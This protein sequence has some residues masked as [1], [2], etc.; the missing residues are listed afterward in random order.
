MGRLVLIGASAILAGHGLI[1]LI[2]AAVYLRLS[3]VQGFSHKTTL[4]GGRWDLWERGIAVYGALWAAA[5]VGF[6]LAAAAM[7]AGWG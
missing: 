5:A 3:T 6:I 7:A 4:L 1:H 2:G